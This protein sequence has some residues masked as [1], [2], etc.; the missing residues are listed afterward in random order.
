MAPTTNNK[1]LEKDLADI[2]VSFNPIFKGSTVKFTPKTSK[3]TK[4][5]ISKKN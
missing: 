2:L 3:T 5:K 4:S 1:Q